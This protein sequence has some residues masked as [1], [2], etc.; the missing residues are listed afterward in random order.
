MLRCIRCNK[1]IPNPKHPLSIICSACLEENP[2]HTAKEK[3]ERNLWD[4]LDSV[5]EIYQKM[6]NKE[7]FWFKNMD[8]KYIDVRIDMRDG[9]CI[10]KQRSGVRINPEELAWQ[11][12]EENPKPPKFG[13]ISVKTNENYGEY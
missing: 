7:W 3:N 4:H 12:S 6:K 2:K 11:Y 5:I 1:Q 10:I 9:G 8:C 13:D